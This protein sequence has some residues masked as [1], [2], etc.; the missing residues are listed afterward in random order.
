MSDKFN[1]TNPSCEIHMTG[2]KVS[3]ESIE[4]AKRVNA[5]HEFWKVVSHEISEKVANCAQRIDPLP[6]NIKATVI[7]KYDQHDTPPLTE[8]TLIWNHHR[9]RP[10]RSETHERE[11]REMPP[12]TK[13]DAPMYHHEITGFEI[14]NTSDGGDVTVEE[15]PSDPFKNF[16]NCTPHAIV[17]ENTSGQTYTLEPSDLYTLRLS[18]IPGKK[19]E[20][21]G[22]IPV[23]G[24][25]R[26]GMVENSRADV[27]LP[28]ANKSLVVSA[29]IATE[30]LQE[31]K[32]LGYS[33][34]Y[35]PDTGKTCKRDAQGNIKACTRL[36][37]HDM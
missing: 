9:H 20:E 16:L 26:Y 36:I 32:Q 25:T 14:V 24:R 4:E 28:V 11:A 27:G 18:E 22:G 10:A 13:L 8:P 34:I 19:I 29:L 1:I 3:R 17:M 12:V 7:L 15:V 37:R 5:E 35:S 6:E 30:A 33:G 2:F 31:L 21:H 23:Y